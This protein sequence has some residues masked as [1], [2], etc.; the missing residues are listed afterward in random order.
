MIWVRNYGHL[1]NRLLV[2][3]NERKTPFK[4]QF[5][6]FVTNYDGLHFFGCAIYYHIAK[7]KFD[8]K[9][10]SEIFLDFSLGVK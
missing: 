2:V 8:S 6:H 1:T 3:T 7:S 9:T 10:K 4:I 5:S